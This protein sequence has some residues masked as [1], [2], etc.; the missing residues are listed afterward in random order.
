MSESP[1]TTRLWT[2]WRG[3]RGGAVTVAVLCALLQGAA[4]DVG[5]QERRAEPLGPEAVESAPRPLPLLAPFGTFQAS[6]IMRQAA[7]SLKRLIGDGVVDSSVTLTALLD[8]R[9]VRLNPLCSEAVDSRLSEVLAGSFQLALAKV[10]GRR[11]CAALFENLG[12]NG[13]V[14]LA[15]T[16]YLLPSGSAAPARCRGGATAVTTLGSP[17]TFLCPCF[18]QISRREGAIVLLHEALHYAGLSEQPLDPAGLT[19]QQISAMVASA[20]RL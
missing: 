6:P 5:A 18:T 14:L 11:E 16:I 9:P 10:Q 20:C 13:A 7:A 2:P 12:A 1:S 8:H 15:T 3:R 19:P 17:V 4:A